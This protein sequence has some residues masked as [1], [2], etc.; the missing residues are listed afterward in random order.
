MIGSASVHY[1][2]GTYGDRLA[3]A[4][5]SIFERESLLTRKTEKLLSSGREDEVRL[6]A[7]G[8]TSPSIQGSVIP[9][10]QPFLHED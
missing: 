8:F 1:D 10:I 2:R 9:T 6:Y 4:R 7:R 3:N 5:E